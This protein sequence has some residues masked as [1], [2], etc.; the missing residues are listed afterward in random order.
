MQKFI[1]KIIFAVVLLLSPYTASAGQCITVSPAQLAIPEIQQLALQYLFTGGHPEHKPPGIEYCFSGAGEMMFSQEMYLL[2]HGSGLEINKATM[3]VER[4]IEELDSFV[5]ESLPDTSCTDPVTLKESKRIWRDYAPFHWVSND[6]Q[7]V[8]FLVGHVPCGTT[9]GAGVS[10]K[11]R[12]LWH[13]HFGGLLTKAEGL[14]L[15]QSE[16]YVKTF[17]E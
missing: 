3:F 10:D 5:P 6:E 8:L 1:Q 11:E 7:K 4:P 13:D 17:G 16:T 12:R 14:A 15:L 2:A 9:A